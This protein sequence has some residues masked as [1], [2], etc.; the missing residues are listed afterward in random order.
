MDLRLSV[1][2]QYMARCGGAA[3]AAACSP[4]LRSMACRTSQPVADPVPGVSLIAAVQTLR[5]LQALSPRHHGSYSM[6]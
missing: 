3:P 4:M 1:R 2:L 5:G 6:E